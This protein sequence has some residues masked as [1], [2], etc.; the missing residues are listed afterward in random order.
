MKTL[1]LKRQ[2][3]GLPA[4]LV[5]SALAMLAALCA[6]YMALSA[7]SKRLSHQTRAAVEAPAEPEP[8]TLQFRPGIDAKTA[9]EMNAAIP[10]STEPLVDARP[11]AVNLPSIDAG[12]RLS[13]VD[14]LTA[15]VYYEAASETPTGQRAVAQVVLN[16]VRHPAYPNSVCGVVFQGSQRKTGCQFTFTCDGALNRPPSA[17]GWARARGVAVA[18]LAGYV[19]PSVGLATH[20]HTQWVVPYW[21]ANLTKLRTV[22]AHIFYR[23]NGSAGTRSAF[24]NAYAKS[25]IIPAS[26]MASLSGFFLSAPPQV[27]AAVPVDTS[28]AQPAPA[29]VAAAS[30]ALLVRSGGELS[31]AP[32]GAIETRGGNLEKPEYRLKSDAVEHRF[33]DD[34]GTLR[35]AQ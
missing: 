5:A 21:S 15:A 18:A 2:T 34:R 3:W 23:W 13:A 19:E 33:I 26:A 1:R 14:C 27:D 4:L 24:T 17:S 29:T 12:T 7:P 28:L 20:Y 22:G 30:S 16:R 10:Q 31:T 11:F 9:A 32:R 6:V 25:E 35:D 8:E